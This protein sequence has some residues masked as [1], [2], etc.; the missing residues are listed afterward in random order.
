MHADQDKEDEESVYFEG[1]REREEGKGYL[2]SHLGCVGVEENPFLLA[3]ITNLLQRLKD[4]NL[5]IHRDHRHKHSVLSNSILQLR[6]K[7]EGN[8]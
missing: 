1:D 3:Y 8:R 4:P 6:E 7:S 5:V 2:P